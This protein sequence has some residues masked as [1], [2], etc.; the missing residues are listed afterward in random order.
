MRV[1]R[2]SDR[3]GCNMIDFSFLEESNTSTAA[4]DQIEKQAAEKDKAYVMFE[5]RQAAYKR[6]TEVYKQYAENIK[7]SEQ[8]RIEIHKDITAG[9]DPKQILIKAAEVIYR[10]TEDKV[11]FDK[12][13]GYVK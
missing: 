10:L 9:A 6:Y 1:C 2:E 5:R 13:V 8:L 11:I 7:K 3:K 4:A 12:I